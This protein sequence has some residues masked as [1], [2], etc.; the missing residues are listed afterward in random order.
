MDSESWV[1]ILYKATCVLLR[2]NL[3]TCLLRQG[4]ISGQ[5]GLFSSGK[6][7][8]LGEG[9]TLN[10]KPEECCWEESLVHLC[11]I[12]LRFIFLRSGFFFTVPQHYKHVTCRRVRTPVKAFFSFSH[13]EGLFLLASDSRNGGLAA[14]IVMGKSQGFFLEEGGGSK[15]LCSFPDKQSLG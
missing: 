10:L 9:K 3:N 8:C 15:I 2:K 1:Q 7:T 5:T 13:L 6:A 14:P 11:N 4:K 12:L